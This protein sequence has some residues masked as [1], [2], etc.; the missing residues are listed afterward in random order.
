[1]ILIKKPPYIRS[2]IKVVFY[3]Q[4]LIAT[5]VNGVNSFIDSS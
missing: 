4:N 1:M 2:F 5:K 3:C